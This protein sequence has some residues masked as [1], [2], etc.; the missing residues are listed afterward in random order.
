MKRQLSLKARQAANLSK[1]N[2]GDINRNPQKYITLQESFLIMQREKRISLA[3]RQILSAALKYAQQFD[4]SATLRTINAE[5]IKSFQLYLTTTPKFVGRGF[6]S[7]TTINDYMSKLRSLLSW[8]EGKELISRNPFCS[9]DISDR[10]P[11]DSKPKGHLTVDEVNSLIRTDCSNPIIKQAF[12]FACFTGLR[13]GDIRNLKWS[14]LQED[15][16]NLTL[17]IKM[18]KTGKPIT[19]PLSDAA[20]TWLPSRVGDYIFPLPAKSHVG[21]IIASW[22]KSAGINKHVTFHIARHTFATL[23]L[24]AGVD[25]YTISCLLG[26]SSVAVTQVYADIVS[27][28]KLRA[29]NALSSLFTTS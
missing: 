7:N 10:L 16:S 3:K 24:S 17:E 22:A 2:N 5:W 21:K 13:I 6:L 26:H 23:S 11:S 8:C 12:L 15:R 27:E 18:Q 25:I 19:I 20:R 14:D 29:V 9:L 1:K 28:E 4:S